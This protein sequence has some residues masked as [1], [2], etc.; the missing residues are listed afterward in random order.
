MLITL[1]RLTGLVPLEALGGAAAVAFYF[2]NRA[3]ISILLV[4]EDRIAVLERSRRSMDAYMAGVIEG[5]VGDL[6][7][8]EY[9]TDRRGSL[10]GELWGVGGYCVGVAPPPDVRE[11]GRDP[12]PLLQWVI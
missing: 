2:L 8:R 5:M 6:R 3:A 12:P 4:P 9:Q 10:S 11:K 7:W 1:G